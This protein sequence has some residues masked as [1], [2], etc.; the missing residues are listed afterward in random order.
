M[1]Y[2]KAIILGT[3]LAIYYGNN[4]L[5]FPFIYRSPEQMGLQKA[6]FYRYKNDDVLGTLTIDL[7]VLNCL[8]RDT[9][10]LYG[11]AEHYIKEKV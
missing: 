6:T 9:K 3:G 11:K 2:I 4:A 1:G 5:P 7:A 10:W 8:W